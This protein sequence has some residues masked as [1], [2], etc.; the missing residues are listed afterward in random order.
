MR[1]DHDGL[2]PAAEVPRQPVDA[3]D[4]EVVRRLIED[5]QVVV[6]DECP[7]QRHPPALAAGE[8]GQ[9]PVQHRVEVRALAEESREHLPDPCVGG[10]LVR[11]SVTDHLGPHG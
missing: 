10:P 5:Q 4:V 8:R 11:R 6:A 7:G 1:H 9:G 3:L 2:A